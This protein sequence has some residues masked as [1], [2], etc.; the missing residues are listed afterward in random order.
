[1]TSSFESQIRHFTGSNHQ[2]IAALASAISTNNWKAVSSLVTR[3]SA[4]EVTASIANLVNSSQAAMKEF[5]G[6]LE[7]EFPPAALRFLTGESSAAWAARHLPRLL[8][9][10][11]FSE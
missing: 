6:R 7:A 5:T 1:M 3:V 2:N 8:V 11:P 10:R 4:L 9:W